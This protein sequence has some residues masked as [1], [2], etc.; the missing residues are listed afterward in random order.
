MSQT[1]AASGHLFHYFDFAM[2]IG[3]SIAALKAH[4]RSRTQAA[5]QKLATEEIAAEL[6]TKLELPG[7]FIAIF[8]GILL[9]VHNPMV[10]K[11]SSAL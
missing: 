8:G 11:A 6:V 2:A 1:L 7:L 10:M 5:E 3:G 4:K 9:V